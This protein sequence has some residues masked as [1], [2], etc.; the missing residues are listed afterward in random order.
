MEFTMDIRKAAKLIQV[1]GVSAGDVFKAKA[2]YI[3]R[4]IYK[5]DEAEFH[6]KAVADL[7]KSK[8]IVTQSVVFNQDPPE[9]TVLELVAETD[10][11]VYPHYLGCPHDA[12]VYS[13]QDY[14]CKNARNLKMF[15]SKAAADLGDGQPAHFFGL[16][17]HN[18]ESI[19]VFYPSQRS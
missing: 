7:T 8:A 16:A 19:E 13:F 6:Y 10:A 5:Y 12:Y 3:G 9:V 1:T 15:F 2:G 11:T 18:L 14:T 4:Y 17:D